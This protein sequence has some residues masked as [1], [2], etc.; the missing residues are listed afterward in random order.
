MTSFLGGRC[1]RH[2]QCHVGLQT[3]VPEAVK[4]LYHSMVAVVQNDR[5]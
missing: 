2:L 4:G 3:M 1:Y 5:V